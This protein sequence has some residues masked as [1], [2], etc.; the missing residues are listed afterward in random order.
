MSGT[1]GPTEVS[2]GPLGLL[3]PGGQWWV[4]L[5]PPNL[6]VKVLLALRF[7]IR[8]FLQ[9]CLLFLFSF[10]LKTML[11]QDLIWAL[12]YPM[13][14]LLT[15]HKP[16]RTE[17]C[18]LLLG[19]RSSA[20]GLCTSPTLSSTFWY[21][22]H[23]HYPLYLNPLGWSLRPQLLLKTICDRCSPPITTDRSK[24]PPSLTKAFM[25]RS[26]DVCEYSIER[27]SSLS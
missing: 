2:L 7:P 19:I 17:I 22:S 13:P 24:S 27:E 20:H 18:Q 25:S 11:T 4:L 16:T 14:E 8:V 1:H 21:C 10:S 12:S 3:S 15:I 23:F 6:Q 26:N 9:C 5:V